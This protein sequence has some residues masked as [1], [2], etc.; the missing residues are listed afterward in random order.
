MTPS[1]RRRAV[2]TINRGLERFSVQLVRAGHDWSDTT[3]FIPFEETRSA[4][5]ASGLSIGDYVEKQSG[6]SQKTIDFMT[7]LGVFD[8]ALEGVVEVGPGTGR[9]LEKMLSHCVAG[10]YE[11]YETAGPWRDYLKQR[12]SV[13]SK[14]VDGYTLAGTRSRSVDLAH[15]H[16]VFCSV[17]FMVTCSY[18]SEFCRVVRGGGW[19]V[20][21]IMSEHCLE[22]D[23]TQAWVDSQI[24]NGSF[25]AVMPFEVT[26]DY[27]ERR[28]FQLVG[29]ILI[30]MPPGST[31]VLAFRKS[32]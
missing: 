1:A 8:R 18:W 13:N 24:H 16:K 20:F 23:R 7:G 25:P 11:I 6:T 15:A 31:E 2:S 3:S 12:F 17:P 26:R 10:T 14:E 9:Y 19:A 29:S 22:N 21:D 5:E 32:A 30:D 4:A 27:F 28:G